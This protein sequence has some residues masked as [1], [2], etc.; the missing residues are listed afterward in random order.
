MSYEALALKQRPQK[1]SDLTGQEAALVTLANGLKTGRLHPVCL[2]TGPRGTGKT[3]AARILAKALRCENKPAPDIPCCACEECLSIHKSQNLNVTEIDGASNNGV[4]AIRELRDVLSYMP[5]SGSQKVYIIDEVHM[6]STSAFNALLK[7]LEEPPSHIQFIMATTEAHKIPLTVTSRCQKFDFHLI[8]PRLL[9]ER[10]EKTSRE[11]NIAIDDKT[12]W[13]LAKRAGGSLRDGHSLLDQTAVFCNGKI[14]YEKAASILCL[15]HPELIEKALGALCRK[16]E[17]KML[18]VIE[19]RRSAGADPKLF[20]EN[21][22]EGL[23]DLLLLK[24]NPKNNPPLV[25]RP[26]KETEAMKAFSQEIG[27]EDLH[28]LFDLALKGERDQALCHDGDLALDVLL[29]K[30]AA[31]PRLERFIPF[32]PLLP[33]PDAE[34]LVAENRKSSLPQ[35]V[36]KTEKVRSLAPGASAEE[37]K[38][39]KAETDPPAAGGGERKE[40]EKSASSLDASAVASAGAASAGAAGVAEK[41]PAGDAGAGDSSDAGAAAK[42][43]EPT[44]GGAR[45]DGALS[46]DRE[47]AKDREKTKEEKA[48]EEKTKEEKTTKEKAEE[49]WPEFMK[50]LK[51]ESPFLEPALGLCS[52]QGRKGDRFL[53]RLPDSSYARNKVME[54]AQF[55]EERLNVFLKAE[56][57]RFAIRFQG[58]DEDEDEDENDNGGGDDGNDGNDGNDNDS[59]KKESRKTEKTTSLKQVLEGE[60]LLE[61]VKEAEEEKE[62][63]VKAATGEK[64]EETKAAPVTKAKEK[65]ETDPPSAASLEE[66]PSAE[67]SPAVQVSEKPQN[68]KGGE[69]STENGESGADRSHPKPD[70]GKPATGLGPS[71]KPATNLNLSGKPDSDKSATSLGPSGKPDSVKAA[72]HG[73]ASGAEESAEESKTA[74]VLAD[75][76]R[77]KEEEERGRK[78]QQ[79]PFLQTLARL[80]EGEIAVEG[81]PISS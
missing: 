67:A 27:A 5:S 74:P 49:I 53:L 73:K 69:T 47:K 57:R 31:A 11:E 9:K 76:K 42:A 77:Q 70:S 26:E 51:S 21:I 13:L 61:E 3:S 79:D 56:D 28:F 48:K 19:E 44:G 60:D 46:L 34:E 4:E 33:E 45:R 58:F 37:T 52:L 50:T 68:N 35:A 80:S 16:D 18:S 55:L 17:G 24:Q 8:P 41:S 40:S 71:G 23:R 64:E 65:A 66:A 2:F 30:L 6:L 20:L 75:L 78:I 72:T 10:L 12:L 36:L 81:K 54:K 39:K 15:S 32:N 25:N 62:E 22:I 14:T 43:T 1:F 63:K 7:T 59:E 38:E 29:L